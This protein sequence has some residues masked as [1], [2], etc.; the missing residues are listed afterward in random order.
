MRYRRASSAPE[1]RQPQGKVGGGE[2]GWGWGCA[3]GTRTLRAAAGLSQPRGAAPPGPAFLRQSPSAT[4]P[5]TVGRGTSS[6]DPNLPVPCLS[7][8]TD[9]SGTVPTRFPPPLPPSLPPT[10]DHSLLPHP[11]AVKGPARGARHVRRSG[12]GQPLSDWRSR[13]AGPLLRDG[14]RGG[15]GRSGAAVG[16]GEATAA[17][18]AQRLRGSGARSARAERRARMRK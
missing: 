13:W 6:G 2:A 7:P 16:G 17:T 3:E 14:G 18:T 4:P 10:G 12:P 9:L 1:P 15:A 5:L 8:A 11:G